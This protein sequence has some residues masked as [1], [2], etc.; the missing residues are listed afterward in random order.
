[1]ALF[2]TMAAC[3]SRVL[4]EREPGTIVFLIETYPSS[5]D[6]RI[7]TDA[8]S[9][10]IQGL[11]FN[12]LVRRNA[13][14]EV[15]PDLATLWEI[16][17]AK[18]YIFHLRPGVRF[19]DGRPLTSAD[20]RYTFESIL[21]GKVASVKAAVFQD[22]LAM[23]TPD[24]Q[25]VIFRLKEPFAA[26]LWNL[27][28]PGIGII[29]EGS[30]KDFGRNPVGSGPYRFIGSKQE[31]E[32]VIERNPLYFREPSKI[33]R[34][35][36][37]VVPEAITRALELERGSADVALNS[38]A[39]DMIPVL[40]EN[41][42][43]RLTQS[44]GTAFAYIAMNL[45][46]PFLARREVRQALAY[47]I[48]REL[49]LRSLFRGLGRL[50]DNILPPNHWAYEPDVRRYSYDP[51]RARALLD[52]AGLRPNDNGV[53]FALSL[54]TST[55]ESA[56]LLAAVLQDQ[57]SRVGIRLEVRSLEFA[58]FYSDITHGSFQLYTLRWIGG[59]NDPDIFDYAFHSARVPPRGANRGHYHN[60]EVD[61]LL[62]LARSESDQAKQKVYYSRLQRIL[63]EDL[64]YIPLWY[65]DNVAVTG[66]R[67]DP[68]QLD[69]GGNFDFLETI[70]LGK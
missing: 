3:K 59:N 48:D 44:P 5:L 63:A 58:T 65:L 67:L 9:Q 53:R 8:Q 6:P 35:R 41:P 29:P 14:M 54:K 22:I 42:A 16:P 52:A 24:P 37:R 49:I 33:E 26:F 4:S 13:H 28:L 68:P 31:E 7:A 11:I 34:V 61:R 19:H 62:A 15:I 60:P 69:P 12:S 47:A 17:D 55:E 30:G 18:T 46:D 38:L 40:Q 45:D 64:P 20:V 27:V 21:S 23:E 50:A 1:V 51:E 56:R 66:K 10:Y 39:P 25:T 70:G 43:L 2:A 57:L 32:I 36:F